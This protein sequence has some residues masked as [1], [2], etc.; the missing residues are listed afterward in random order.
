MKYEK[1]LMPPVIIALLL[2]CHRPQLA[3]KFAKVQFLEFA[4]LNSKTKIHVF[5]NFLNRAVLN[6]PDLRRSEENES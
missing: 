5:N 4:L 6:V 2:P 1:L 3:L